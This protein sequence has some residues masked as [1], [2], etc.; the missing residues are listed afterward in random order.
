MKEA[1]VDEGVLINSNQFDGLNSHKEASKNII[2][3][4]MNEGV[5]E[6]LDTFRLR[7]WL[8][9]RQRY[10]GCPIP[11]INCNNCGL[12]PEKIDNLPVLL[13][14]IDDYLNNEGSPLS[15]V[16]EFVNVDCPVCG[17]NALRETD[18]M[19]TFVDSSWY[20]M[21]YLSPDSTDSP[22]DRDAVN[23]WLPVDQYIGGVEHAILH[24]LYSRFF[25][26]A[27]R[28]MG[29]ID[30]SEPFNNLFAQGMINFGGSKMSKSK[31]N[32]VSPEAYFDSHGA[33]SLRLYH[34]F[35]GP[36]SDS[37]E[38][39][40]NGIEGTRR[41]LNKV[42]ENMFALSK[43]DESKS[44]DTITETLLIELN[45]TI[46]ST[47]KDL[48]SF[49][50][51]TIVSD[52]MK[53]NNVLSEFLK[54]DRTISKNSREVIVK[55]FLTLLYP[56]AP[57]ISSE[58]LKEIL[59]EEE[60]VDWPQVDERYLRDKSFEL[61][62]QVNGKKKSAKIV[63]SDISEEEAVSVAKQLLPEVDIEGSK[64]I[65]FVKNKLINFVI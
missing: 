23:E 54:I 29:L 57:H 64:K 33:D 60:F 8:I 38:W 37:V 50:F 40:D 45:K 5:G 20:Y 15:K 44:D 24:L 1:F 16:S 43:M 12:V 32:I 52:L 3:W 39:N 27:L 10:W 59:G 51:N 21:R 53:F 22:F 19:D 14:E 11:M 7:D 4:L 63:D 58:L 36:P 6:E 56:L 46:N 17:S 31:G 55:N 35:M 13:P 2:N 26:K 47:T 65:I 41:F 48:E 25:T 30:V 62:I 28:D 34:L 61:V 42:W 18:T 9:S 49:D